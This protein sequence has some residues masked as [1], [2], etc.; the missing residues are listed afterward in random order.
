MRKRS[1][2]N[3][4]NACIMYNQNIKLRFRPTLKEESENLPVSFM[5]E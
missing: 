1:V 4:P 3:K 5:L 2:F